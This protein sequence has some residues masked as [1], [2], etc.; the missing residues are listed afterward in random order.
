MRKYNAMNGK[1][2]HI[3]DVWISKPVW[4]ERE[5]GKLCYEYPPH[6]ALLH[7]GYLLNQNN[8]TMKL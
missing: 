1:L 8:N 2:N 5:Y 4:S 3:R 7:T 6:S